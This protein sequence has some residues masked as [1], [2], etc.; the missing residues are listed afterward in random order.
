MA[1]TASVV[2]RTHI[3]LGLE[4]NGL[5]DEWLGIAANRGLV[6]LLVERA[7]QRSGQCDGRCLVRR[8]VE[9][10][11]RFDEYEL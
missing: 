6:R 5:V 1:A 2:V 3:G 11:D 7:S 9:P 8:D 10:I 4:R